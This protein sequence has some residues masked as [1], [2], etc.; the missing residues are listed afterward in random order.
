[1]AISAQPPPDVTLV[2]RRLAVLSL[3]LCCA[4][5]YLE[6]HRASQSPADLAGHNCLR[7]PYGPFAEGW[8]FLDAGGNP[9]MV[10]I[11]GSL[12]SNSPESLRAP[13]WLESA[14]S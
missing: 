2:K 7:Y 4:P 1:L 9:L 3:M 12:I 11:S 6:R 13:P 10:R 14:W 8:H 5:A